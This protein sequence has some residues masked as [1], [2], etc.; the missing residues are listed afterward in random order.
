MRAVP[1][2]SREFWNSIAQPGYSA[3]SAL[4]SSSVFSGKDKQEG[5]RAPPELLEVA[6]GGTGAARRAL[7]QMPGACAG[8]Q[9]ID[10][11]AD[12]SLAEHVGG[13]AGYEASELQRRALAAYFRAGGDG[14]PDPALSTVEEHDGKRYVMLRN[15]SGSLACYRI[16]KF[17][18]VLKR[19]VRIPRELRDD[20]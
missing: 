14:H 3:G 5:F 2:G 4:A 9:R 20:E 15:A 6:R 19:L 11:G 7:H 1:R 17:D 16:R 12:P 13:R 10:L 8:L 18:G